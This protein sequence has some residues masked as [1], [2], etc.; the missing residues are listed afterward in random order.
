MT[1][2]WSL[3]VSIDSSQIKFYEIFLVLSQG[4]IFGL[5]LI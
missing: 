3:A 5:Q 4:S 1:D 2:K